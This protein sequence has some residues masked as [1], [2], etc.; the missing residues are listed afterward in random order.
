MKTPGP[1]NISILIL[2]TVLTSCSKQNWYAGTQA[3][4]TA[5]C[6]QEPLSE[7]EDCI[8]Q[9]TESY[10]DYSKSREQLKKENQSK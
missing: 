9:S 3:A 6:M 7:Y 1:E 8:Q 5:H 10:D 4:Q 2:L